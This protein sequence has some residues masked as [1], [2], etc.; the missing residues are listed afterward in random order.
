MSDNALQ[1]NTLRPSSYISK[2]GL[3]LSV[4]GIAV[5][6]GN[7]WRFPRIA[8]SAGGE[9]GAG[10]FLVA[11]VVFLF[12]WSIPLIVAEYAL[13]RWT[14]KSVITAFFKTG[15]EKQTWKG[16]FVVLVAVA[17]MAYYGVITGWCFWYFGQSLVFALPQTNEASIAGWNAFQASY[18]P[19]LMQI[20]VFALAGV[21]VRGGIRWIERLSLVLIP[22]LFIAM[23]IMLIRAVTL[24]GSDMGLHYLFSFQWTDLMQ[25][26]VWLEALTQNAWDTGAGWGL[27]LS[28]AAFAGS[29]DHI[30]KNAFKTGIANNLMSLIAAITI[31]STVFGVLGATMS[32]SEIVGVLKSGGP[33]STGL[34]FIWIPAL[35]ESIPGGSVLAMVFFGGLSMAAFTSFISMVQLGSRTMIEL[36]YGPIV[37]LW[38]VLGAGFLAGSFSAADVEVLANQDFVWGLALMVSGLFIA[39]LISRYG[40]EAFAREAINTVEDDFKA[41]LFWQL[42]MRFFI[43]AQAVLLLGWWFWRSIT[44]FTPGSWMNPLV[45]YSLAN[46]LMYW[47]AGTVVL[48]ILNRWMNNRVIRS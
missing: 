28:Y 4:L 41:G 42:S 13:G 21:V 30:V 15:G 1:G 16:A 3:L 48:V 46:C 44:E 20:I 23:F 17:I 25:S 40:A 24:P 45:P 36:D 26:R 8:A 47:A 9:Q 2:F 18:G 38:G 27:I 11:W 29:R 14:G 35:F 33:A 31:F 43:P 7:I 10:A 39:F 22:S 6:T 12:V 19:F 37:S 34:T 32:Q 5:G